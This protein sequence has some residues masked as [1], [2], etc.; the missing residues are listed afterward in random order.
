MQQPT[1]DDTEVRQLHRQLDTALREL[2]TLWRRV[3]HELDLASRVH[4]SL[5][6]DPVRDGPVHVD[7]R[8]IPIEQVGGDYCQVAFPSADFCH[9]SI[10]DVT[11]HGIGSALLA[12]CVSS[13]VRHALFYDRAPRDIVRSLNRFVYEHFAD[14]PM[15]L[16]FMATRID[17]VRREVTYS[18]AGHPSPLL[19]RRRDRSAVRLNSQNLLLGV[20]EDALAP[21]SETTLPMEPGDRLV[22][23]TDGLT[24]TMTADGHPLRMQE[25]T[26]IVASAMDVD[27]FEMA[28][29]VLD[30]VTQHQHSAPMDDITLIVAELQP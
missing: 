2:A 11:G 29:F 18:G 25:L 9:I 19:V 6:P 15:F 30:Q 16:S 10:T 23:Y 5:L 27:L 1:V 3:R 7:I 24:D 8:Y 4:R 22:F 26:E 13:E 14:T 21:E 28:D 17:V 12:A 20:L